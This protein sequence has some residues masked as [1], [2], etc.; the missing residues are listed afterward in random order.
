MKFKTTFIS[1]ELVKFSWS[2]FGVLALIIKVIS[3]AADIAE[4]LWRKISGQLQF[5][6]LQLNGY[7]FWGTNSC[8]FCLPFHLDSTLK[9]FAPTNKCTLPI[10]VINHKTM[11]LCPTFT[12]SITKLVFKVSPV[13]YF[14]KKMHLKILSHHPQK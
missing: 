5:N 11:S 4:S 8:H 12:K 13:T 7:T 3:L 9:E 6:W 14:Y 1:K 2:N 10:R